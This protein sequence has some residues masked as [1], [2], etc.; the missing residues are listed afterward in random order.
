M[1][2]KTNVH[3][4]S[5]QAHR[6]GRLFRPASL[7]IECA[8]VLPLFF[9]FCITLASFMN[10]LRLQT[11]ENLALSNRARAM[12]MVASDPDETSVEWIDLPE[13][14]HFSY[15]SLIPGISSLNIACH[16]RVHVWNGTPITKA[17]AA[18]DSEMVYVSDTESVYHT[19]ADCSHIA[20][21][22]FVSTTD[23]IS[24]LRSEDGHR[25]KKC[26]GFPSGYS[27]PVY[28]SKTGEYYYPSSDYAALTRHVRCIPKNELSNPNLPK[29]SRCA[30]RDAA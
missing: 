21:S 8:F 15:P 30:A 2:A 4:K 5:V 28:A 17:A 9:F 12:A 1:P 23:E 26:R 25:Y 29:C 22:V 10:A 6:Q 19:H 24:S 11:T 20:L 13:I 3:I 7:T 16:A 18:D 27:G 14:K